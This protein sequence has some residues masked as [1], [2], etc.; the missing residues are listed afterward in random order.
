MQENLETPIPVYVLTGFLGSGKTTLLCNMLAY[1]KASGKKPAVIMNEVGDVNIDGMLIDDEVPVAE[2]LSGCICCTIRSDLSIEL[3]EVIREH[4]PDVVL[5]E[6]TGVAKPVDVLESITDTA[7]LTPLRLQRVVTVVDA[8]AMSDEFPRAS[9]RTQHLMQDQI[10]C[11]DTIVVNKTD[12]VEPRRLPELMGELRRWNRQAELVFTTHCHVDMQMLGAAGTEPI[13]REN[14]SGRSCGSEHD[15]HEHHE[16]HEHHDRHTHSHPHDHVTVHME[17]F[18]E[19]LDRDRFEQFVREMPEEV[20]RAK[21][22]L[23]FSDTGERHLFQ[24]AYR[25]MELLRV[26]PQKP[27]KDLMVLIGENMPKAQIAERIAALTKPL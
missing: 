6:C 11:A 17:Y 20:Y 14:P 23:R 25:S 16:H 7:M 9:K 5:I 19:P 24:Y 26:R 22:I 4:S 8:G 2:L 3:S 13:F 21:G 1:L 27:V 18:S 10:R 12:S 15:N